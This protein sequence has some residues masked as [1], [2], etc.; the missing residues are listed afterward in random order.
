MEGFIHPALLT[1]LVYRFGIPGHATRNLHRVQANGQCFLS[2]RETLLRTEAFAHA[3]SSLCEDITIARRIAECGERVGFY[4][5]GALVEVAMYSGWR[6]A[7]REWP[8]SLP[9]RDQYFGW[10]EAA[11]LLRVLALQALPL[12]LFTAAWIWRAPRVWLLS[13]A[14]LLLIRV[15][16]LCG[17]ARAYPDRPWTYWLSPL[18]DLP[19]VL[20]VLQSALARRHTWRGR[21]YTRGKGGKFA[22]AE[23]R[24]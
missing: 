9:M 20:R 24:A 2:R 19:A 17:T 8:R 3:R 5:A 18:C 4:E 13:T 22:P 10:R 14:L 11:G 12:P 15:G 23:R 16:V 1:T 21:S 6:E 7:W